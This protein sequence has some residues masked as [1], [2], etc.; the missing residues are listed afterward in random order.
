MRERT[1]TC[2]IAT[3]RKELQEA[4][5]P[6]YTWY[7]KLFSPFTKLKVRLEEKRQTKKF[8]YQRA[9]K[10][11]T[12]CDVWEMRT[13]FLNTARPILLEMAEKMNNHPEE[14]TFE[15]WRDVINRM[16]HLLELMD[17]WND[18]SLRAECGVSADDKS[19]DTAVRLSETR[20][21]AKEEFFSLFN[22]WFYS[23][24][25]NSAGQSSQ[26]DIYK[27]FCQFHLYSISRSREN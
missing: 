20:N 10:G 19:H 7:E 15:E 17:I 3:S 18:G 14:I 13:W 12:D 9:K 21:E 24:Y 11:Y 4:L 27:D 6:E 1:K 26:D 22:E 23:L 8:Q 16:A 2:T 25:S 5:K